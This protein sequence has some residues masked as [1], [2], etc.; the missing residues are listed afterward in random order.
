MALYLSERLTCNSY[1]TLDKLIFQFL[2][3]FFRPLFFCQ[4]E[5]KFVKCSHERKE[6][7]FSDSQIFHIDDSSKSSQRI[8]LAFGLLLLFFHR[9]SFTK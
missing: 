6:D 2:Y 3:I 7:S 4:S 9:T 8:L 1:Y 5:E